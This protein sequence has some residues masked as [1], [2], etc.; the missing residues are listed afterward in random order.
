MQIDLKNSIIVLDEAHNVEDVC[1]DAASA[2]L[3]QDNIL[4]AMNDLERMTRLGANPENCQPLVS[5]K[6][7]FSVDF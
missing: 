4:E 3:T 7:I 2:S 6:N 1:R 5:Q